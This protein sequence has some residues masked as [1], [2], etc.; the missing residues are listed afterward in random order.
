MDAINNDNLPLDD[1][2]S[3]TGPEC[4]QFVTNNGIPFFP[5]EDLKIIFL[6]FVKDSGKKLLRKYPNGRFFRGQFQHY[7]IEYDPNEFKVN[8]T[9]LF[10]RFLANGDC[11]ELSD[12]IESL[13]RKKLVRY[14]ADRT[15]SGKFT[16]IVRDYFMQQNEDGSWKPYPSRTP[17]VTPILCFD[18][19]TAKRL[20]A[21]VTKLV[22]K[23]HQDTVA[24]TPEEYEDDGWVV[25]VGWDK[26]EVK[27][28]VKEHKAS[29]KRGGEGGFNFEVVKGVVF[30][31]VDEAVLGDYCKTRDEAEEELDS[32]TPTNNQTNKAKGTPKKNTEEAT[33]TT[34][35]FICLR[36]KAAGTIKN[37]NP[38]DHPIPSR[39]LEGEMDFD[40]PDPFTEVVGSIDQEILTLGKKVWFEGRKILDTPMKSGE[41]WESFSW[42]V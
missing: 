33:L 7:G 39:M 28:T 35:Y 23:L 8:R 36:C 9:V 12:H 17:D 1:I 4:P 22:P 27:K 34:K 42:V 38:G 32:D 3:Y 20:S 18:L 25:H 19:K 31:V 24:I 16:S 30:L 26:K 40:G 11:D 14:L 21:L 29:V 6:P 37:V 15:R 41:M 13:R 5:P 2:I 10:Q